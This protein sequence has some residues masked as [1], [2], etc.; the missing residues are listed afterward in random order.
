M[1]AHRVDLSTCNR[2]ARNL[3]TVGLSKMRNIQVTRCKLIQFSYQ[4]NSFNEKSLLLR[5]NAQMRFDDLD[6]IK[7]YDIIIHLTSDVC[8]VM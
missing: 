7:R 1:A 4:K 8:G 3:E 2:T 6:I 5:C